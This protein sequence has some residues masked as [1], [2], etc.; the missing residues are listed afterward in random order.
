M[1]PIEKTIIDRANLLCKNAFMDFPDYDEN[2]PI[3]TLAEA[4]TVFVFDSFQDNDID[5]SEIYDFLNE[6]LK[7]P[8]YETHEEDAMGF[9]T[10]DFTEEERNNFKKSETTEILKTP[11]DFVEKYFP[12][13]S[14]SDEI[15]RNND[16]T[17]AIE[18]GEE[19]L[20][21]QLNESNAYV[22]E[23]AIKGYLKT[24]S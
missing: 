21:D 11:W 4:L 22:F 1:N 18:E 19:G 8:D 6:I 24:L 7:T 3:T 10:G 5:S 14:S 12:N 23:E 15:L 20:E 16:L 17:N 13:Y 9:L 2:N